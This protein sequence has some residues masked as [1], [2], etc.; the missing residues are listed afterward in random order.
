MFTP[1]IFKYVSSNDKPPIL[2]NIKFYDHQKL[3]KEYELKHGKPWNLL[4]KERNLMFYLKLDTPIVIRQRSIY[5]K[6]RRVIL[7]IFLFL[8]NNYFILSFYR[9]ICHQFP[10]FKEYILS[11]H[12]AFPITKSFPISGIE[13]LFP[14]LN[15][16]SL[17]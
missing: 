11:I 14:K 8:S 3:L 6:I 1:L 17:L 7:Y 10:S 12:S 2:E 16:H 4:V 5:M 13:M 15:P 9:I